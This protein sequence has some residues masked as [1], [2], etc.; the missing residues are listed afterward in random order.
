MFDLRFQ[1]VKGL[2]ADFGGQ[3]VD[4]EADPVGIIGTRLILDANGDCSRFPQP[5]DTRGSIG[6][7]GR[8]QIKFQI[9]LV[10]G[11]PAR[12]RSGQSDVV[13]QIERAVGR[14][15]GGDVRA[16]LAGGRR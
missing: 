16:D 10:V 1:R 3:P 9:G 4:F 13:G 12:R 5:I 15:P 14:Q 8:P 11:Q 7:P 6:N 2:P